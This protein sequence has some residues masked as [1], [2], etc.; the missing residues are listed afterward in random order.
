VMGEDLH[1]NSALGVYVLHA[2]VWRNNP[3]GILEDWN[4]E[5]SCP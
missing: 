3:A 1:L 4:P 2:W 5:V